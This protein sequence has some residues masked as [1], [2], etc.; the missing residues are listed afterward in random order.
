MLNTK[1]QTPNT[2]HQTPIG[3]HQARKLALQFSVGPPAEKVSGAPV[4]EAA[5]EDCGGDARTNT[6]EAA[7]ASKGADGGE[8]SGGD[9][10]ADGG[11]D[12]CGGDV[13]GNNAVD[14]SVR[15]EV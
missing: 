9:V 15:W 13:A 2:K 6:G 1:H 7:V 3:R 14:T 10:S 11:A 8:V 12:G 4:T 5:A